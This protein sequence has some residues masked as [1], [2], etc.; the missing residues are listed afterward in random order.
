MTENKNFQALEKQSDTVS[1]PGKPG[2]SAAEKSTRQS[3]KL[4]FAISLNTGVALTLAVVIFGMI[5]YM[6]FR[7]YQHT[8]VSRN[9]LYQ[10][11]DKTQGLLK[12]L[13]NAVDVIVFFQPGQDIY[14]DVDN[15]LK[16]YQ[17][18]SKLIRVQKVDPDRDLARTEMLA[19][20]YQV[21]KPN[22]VVFESNG[23]S[24]FV[25]ADDIVELDYSG[26]QMGA[27]PRKTGFKGEQAF[28]SALLNITQ[29]KVP[30]VYF[31]QG[32][33]ERDPESYDR[34]KGYSALV[35]EI[36]RD[37]ATVTKV[38]L[39]EQKAIPADADVLVIAGPQKRFAPA[40]VEQV[41][42]FITK[43]GRVLFLLDSLTDT[44]LAPLLKEWGVQVG[45]DVVVD[46]TRTLSGNELFVTQYERHP[47]TEKLTGVSSILYL[48]RS[49][50]AIEEATPGADATPDK[51]RVTTLIK[52]TEQ[53]WGETDP[54]ENPLRFDPGVDHKGPVGVAVAVEK[55]GAPGA[56]DTQIKPMRLVVFGDS[57]FLANGALI[58]GNADLV[59]SALNW[60]LDRKELMA[61]APKAV[62]E[63]RLVLDQ[64]QLRLL[65]WVTIGGLPALVAVLGFLVW[66]RRRA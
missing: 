3:R 22:V 52:C 5:N 23:R 7:H 19:K 1:N 17:D 37:N 9:K 18:A 65:G 21:S 4:K 58:G 10:L 38:T 6:S 8:D 13:T 61:I 26:M 20:K 41:K 32:H 11:S 43:N 39:G 55:G 15:L 59:Q 66:L 62:E 42:Q 53:G 48:P 34:A 2:A 24:K 49:V 63:Y 14:E 45:D 64:S 28:S 25:T 56:L 50:E 46:P 57:S 33:G 47:I 31:L 44:G 36:K 60:L 51:P 27:P 16:E 29:A 12:S 30:T 35:R 40:E 54:N